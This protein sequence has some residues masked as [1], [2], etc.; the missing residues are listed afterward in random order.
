ML[1]SLLE[2]KKSPTSMKKGSVMAAGEPNEGY[3]GNCP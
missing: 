2:I 3:V 1:L